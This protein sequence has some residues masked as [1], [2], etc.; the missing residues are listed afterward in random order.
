MWGFT[1]SYCSSLIHDINAVHGMLDVMG[2][3]TGR[4]VGAAFFANGDGG[5]GCVRLVGC[6]GLWQMSHLF[7]PK[8]A[9]YVERITLCFDDAIYEL[10]FP[11]PY[12]NHFPTRLTVSRSQGNVWQK[13]EYR[14]SYE[15]AFIR[16]L[17]GFW[18]SAVEG[19]TVRNTVEA[20]SRDLRL[21]AQLAD[22]ALQG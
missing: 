14:A 9:D 5:H 13:T 12:L 10:T 20:A 8:V 7:V 21:I 4:V 16:E 11:S 6:K 19:K 1:N 3:D 2:V 17:I 15:E 22:V 18:G